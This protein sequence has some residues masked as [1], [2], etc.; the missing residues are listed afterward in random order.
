MIE[1]DYYLDRQYS[2]PPCWELVV[3][4]YAR[5][6]GHPVDRY[7]VVNGGLREAARLFSVRLINDAHGFVRRSEPQEGDIVL[8]GA[9]AKTGIHHAG[10]YVGG[11]VMHALPSGNFLE[12]LGAIGGRYTQVEF[13]GRNG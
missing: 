9:S 3:E 11:K 6:F 4:F 5:E 12:E 2:E 10:V 8:L 13:W 7:A 1:T